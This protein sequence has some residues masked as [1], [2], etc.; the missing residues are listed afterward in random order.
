V[1][2]PDGERVNVEALAG[3]SSGLFILV[4]EPTG[5][6]SMTSN[7]ES[8][9]I[10][11]EDEKE[12]ENEPIKRD[13][14]PPSWP[15]SI[16]FLRRVEEEMKLGDGP[17]TSEQT[18]VETESLNQTEN[19]EQLGVEVE[20]V[21]VGEMDFAS[22]QGRELVENEMEEEMDNTIGSVGDVEMQ[23]LN[24]MEGEQNEVTLRKFFKL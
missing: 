6:E 10:A 3:P 5:W 16:T 24:A 7:V 9:S 1:F 11:D 14:P 15:S 12:N 22:E 13:P 17:A 2:S 20:D 23:Q 4:D 18:S 21:E 19:L 8:K